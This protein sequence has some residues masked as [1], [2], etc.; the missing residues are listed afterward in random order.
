MKIVIAIALV[1][2]A[3]LGGWKVFE[4]WDEVSKDREAKQQASTVQVDPT[5]L[6][7]LPSQFE[8]SLQEAYK[9]GAPG[10]KEW[11]L[12]SKRLPQIKDPR[13][14]WIELDYVLMVTKDDPIEAK[15]IFAE[16]KQRTPPD[17]PVYQRIKTLEKNYE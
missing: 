7:G 1:I 8:T 10:L 9:K 4:Y 15:K 6:D 12:Q 13:L 11:L 17:S 14:A 5:R 2:G 3:V 16:I